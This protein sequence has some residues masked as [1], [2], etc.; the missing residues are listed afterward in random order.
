MKVEEQVCTLKQ[1]IILEKL[2]VNV[3]PLFCYCRVST[4]IDDSY[5]DLLPTQW[6][7]QGIPELATIW[8][9]PAFTVAELGQMLPDEYLRHDFEKEMYFGFGRGIW[10]INNNDWGE[11]SDYSSQCNFHKTEASARASLLIFLLENKVISI[12]TLNK[13]C[14]L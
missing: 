6:N 10:K 11:R 3:E 1:G 7:L 9:A 14:R 13:K 12:E 8:Q 4:S 5:D 2:G